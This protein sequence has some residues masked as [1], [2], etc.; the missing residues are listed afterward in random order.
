MSTPSSR[1]VTAGLTIGMI[2]IFT[3]AGLWGGGISMMGTETVVAAGGGDGQSPIGYG[4]PVV[5]FSSEFFDEDEGQTAQLTLTRTGDTTGTTTVN[6]ATSTGGTATPGVDF[7]PVNTNVTFMPGATEATVP[8]RI[9]PD[10]RIENDEVISIPAPG[11]I[12]VRPSS[13]EVSNT[14]TIRIHDSAAEYDNDEQPL[15]IT[16]GGTSNIYPSNITVSGE[17]EPISDL[18]VTLFDLSHTFPDNIDALLVGPGGQKFILMSKSGGS[19]AIGPNSTI[20]LTFGDDA[21]EVL[22]D[23]GALTWDGFEPT[24]W[25]GPVTN[26]PAPAPAGPYSEPGSA[27]GGTGTQ[28]LSGRFGGTSANGVWSLYLRDNSGVPISPGD[29]DGCFNGGWGLEFAPQSGTTTTITN[30]A[31]LS[32]NPTSVGTSYAVNWTVN[33]VEP[34][35]GTPTGTVTVT[36]GTGATCNAS[37]SAGTCNLTSTTPGLKTITASYSGEEGFAPSTAAGTPHFVYIYVTGNVKQFVAFG[38]NSNL[39]GATI[40]MTGSANQQTTTDANGN[41]TLALSTAGGNYVLTPSGLGKTYEG[42]SRSYSN[43]NGNIANGD[44]VAYNILGPNALP[45]TARVLSQMATQGQPV[46]VPILMSTTG[47]ERR[48]SLTIEYP[49]AALGIPSVTCGTGTVGC[50]LAVNNSLPGRAGITITPVGTLAAGTAEIAKIT[51]PTFPSNASSAAIRFGDFPTTR[52]VRNAENNPL[53]MLYWTDG[54]VSFTGGTLLEGMTLSGRVLTAGG[55]GVRNAVV[56]IIDPVGN[57]RTALT[58]SFGTYQ[59]EGLES[60]RE[61]LITV[62]NKRYRF[63]SRTVQMSGDLSGVDLVGME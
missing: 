41:Y 26:F 27:V 23:F 39:A 24:S 13:P 6:V 20:S 32:S 15:C 2:A 1:L 40:S 63:G 48:V 55:L 29:I 12:G 25:G 42:L 56:T 58:G 38:T 7:E 5:A 44:F 17:T 61:Y 57:R 35:A 60:G 50:T 54:Q 28:T 37:V 9:R 18:R 14:A 30:T 8:V 33:A 46:T 52:D 36:D 51:F 3:F 34:A 10:I 16:R 11:F 47:A 22:P 45:R 59:F 43:V 53:P 62:T 19:N 49:V 4:D 31:S 21:G